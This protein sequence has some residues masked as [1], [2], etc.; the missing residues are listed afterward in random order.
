MALLLSGDLALSAEQQIAHYRAAAAFRRHPSAVVAASG[1]L[2]LARLRHLTGTSRGVLSACGRGL[3][4]LDEHRAGLGS[5]ELRAL[6]TQHGRDLATLALQQVAATGTSRGLLAWSERWRATA[7]AQPP[8]RPPEGAAAALDAAR[9][10]QRALDEARREDE[11]VNTVGVARERRRLERE[12]RSQHHRLSG[13]SGPGAVSRTDVPELLDEL[14]DGPDG[15]TTLVELVEI[16]G[17]LRALVA[18]E[19]RVRGYLVG[20]MDE[21]SAAVDAARFV[22]RQSSRGRPADIT[23]LGER[24]QRTLLGPAARALGDGP[25]VISPPGHLHAT[26]WG[27]LPSLARLPVSVAPSAA[28]WVRARRRDAVGLT[29]LVLVSG[30]GLRSGGAEIDVLAGE[31]PHATVLRGED[32]TVAATLAGLDGALLAHVA[33]HGHFRQDS[34]MFSSLRLADGPLTVHDLEL[35]RRPPH[36]F[37]LSACDSG[38][39][40]PV[41]ADELLGL[42]AALL[43]LGTAGVVASVAE[44]SDEASASV[45]VHLHHA[46][47]EGQSLARALLTVRESACGDR[48]E[49]A[50]AAA[51]VGL[52]V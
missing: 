34:P 39:M 51:F 38:V 22:L 28:T 21:A 24:L 12:V 47:A 7:L 49:E 9:A 32:A 48:I 30:P 16:D 35:L 15:P 20:P 45:M 3:A 8:V 18:R 19:G 46:L 17:T 52:G 14:R 41:G 44:V 5:A 6:S 10:A 42:S 26:P 2:A 11:P 27:L 23:G 13:L 1:W 25:V 36:R 29:G 50:T 43:S 37:V 31:N 33:A 4:A 40:V